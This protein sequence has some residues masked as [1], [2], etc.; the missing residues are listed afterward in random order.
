MMSCEGAKNVSIP[1][2]MFHFLGIH[3]SLN[4]ALS[5]DMSRVAHLM[6]VRGPDGN[7]LASQ[8]LPGI[9]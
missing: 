9:P 4:M 3:F 2:V 5:V 6:S 7:P 8:R 1:H